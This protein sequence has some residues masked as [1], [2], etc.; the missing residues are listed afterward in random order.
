MEL[1]A[2]VGDRTSVF[3]KEEGYVPS[4]IIVNEVVVTHQS[5]NTQGKWK[6]RPIPC[7]G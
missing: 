5:T 4:K 3:Q 7:T 2:I 1:H 6:I